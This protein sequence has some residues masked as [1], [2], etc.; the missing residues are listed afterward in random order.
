MTLTAERPET[1][2][3]TAPARRGPK[4]R[5]PVQ[6]VVAILVAVLVLGVPFWLVIATA[7]KDQAQALNPDL[8]PPSEWRLFDNFA[9]VFADGRM[10]AGFFGSLLVMVPAVIGVLILGSMAAWILGR[11]GG[12]LTAAIYALGISGIVLPPAVVTIV[13]LLRQLGLAGTALGM[14]GVYMGMYL[15]TVIFFVTGFVR[16]IPHELE[17]AARVDGAGPVR[18]FIRVILPLLRPVLA[19]ATILICLYIWND[20]FY[21]LFV[22]GGRLDTLPLNLYQVA[23]AGLYLQNW[24]LIFA[25]I[26]LMSLPLLITFVVAQ[27]RIISGIT[28]GAVK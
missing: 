1:A 27:R 15:S 2:A 19:T 7:A 3:R 6:P 25:Y 14:I 22:V 28:S 20:V 18:T 5:F 17:E 11:R 9:Q 12:K 16:T 21:A 4:R 8:S 10:V 24:H 23:S 26:I 13:L